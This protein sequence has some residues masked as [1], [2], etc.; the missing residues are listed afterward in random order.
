MSEAF[1]LTKSLVDTFV[2][3]CMSSPCSHQNQKHNKVIVKSLYL[4]FELLIS[5]SYDMYE[6]SLNL[7]YFLFFL[8]LFGLF[9]SFKIGKIKYKKKQNKTESDLEHYSC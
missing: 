3:I 4:S 8:F 6:L 9:L 5:Y 1:H 7:T 2:K